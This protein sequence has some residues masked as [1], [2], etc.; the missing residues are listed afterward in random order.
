MSE[1]ISRFVYKIAFVAG[2]SALVFFI[3]DKVYLGAGWGPS[4]NFAIGTFTA[5]VPQGLPATVTVLLSIAASRMAKRK[6]LVKDLQGVETLG[7]ITLLATDKTGTLTRNQMT[8]SYVWTGLTTY[9][10]QAT[11]STVDDY[12][13]MD[14]TK[15]GILDFLY[16]AALCTKAKFD[17]ND[18]PVNQREVFGDATEVGLLRCAG[19][20]LPDADDALAKFPKV[21]EVPF[22][23]E[24]KWALTIHKKS[25]TTGSLTLYLKGA[26][27]RVLRLC[28]KIFDGDSPIPMT[29]ERKATFESTYKFMASKGHRV[30]AFAKL[31]LS[32][33]TF[34]PTF[35]FERDP[36]NY[37]RQGLVFQG[38]VS[39]EDP[40]KH[41]VREAIGKC[42]AA[43]VQV[44][45]VTGD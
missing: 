25:H 19:S 40:P 13:V 8:V 14:T 16:T 39:L 35:A 3:V 29:S 27:E 36:P 7:A 2:L 9:I 20:R 22:N 45:M 26:P 32:E 15:P 23:S 44:M 11:G 30:L 43:G 24:N 6:V 42:R 4:V 18:V 37:P 1:E 17:R 12:P 31:E 21:F 38:L 34:P 41:G 28:D 5:W 10:A 33:A